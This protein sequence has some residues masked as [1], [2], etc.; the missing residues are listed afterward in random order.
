MDVPNGDPALQIGDWCI[1]LGRCSTGLSSTPPVIGIPRSGSISALASLN[2]GLLSDDT[3]HDPKIGMQIT[4]ALWLQLDV[5]RRLHEQLEVHASILL[6]AT[7][8]KGLLSMSQNMILQF[9]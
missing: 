8:N 6:Q 4:G 9:H 5:Q 2:K 3:E 1:S 7:L